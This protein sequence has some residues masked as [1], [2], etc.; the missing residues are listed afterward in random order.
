M[1]IIHEKLKCIDCGTCVSLCPKFFKMD[2]EGKVNLKG[3]K[4][5]KSSFELEV[6][7]ADCAK[8]AAESCP[9]KCILLK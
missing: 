1:K 5:V 6:K 7:D 2:D 9:V 8:E 4:S 3:S